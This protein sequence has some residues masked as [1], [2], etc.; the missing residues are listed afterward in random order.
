VLVCV[1]GKPEAMVNS[2]YINA[3]PESKENSKTDFFII[4]PHDS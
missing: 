3:V 2:G 1:R 4:L